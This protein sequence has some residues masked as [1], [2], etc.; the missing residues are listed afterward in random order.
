M[1]QFQ[2]YIPANHIVRIS[3]RRPE[4]VA[5][6]QH[7]DVYVSGTTLGTV[8]NDIGS[9]VIP[10]APMPRSLELHLWWS[11][12][13]GEGVQKVVERRTAA[14]HWELDCYDGWGD[15]KI[16]HCIQLRIEP[17]ALG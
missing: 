2:A 10:A 7:I 12:N 11:G 17:D 1:G 5:F 3:A 13:H 8:S 15:D 16:D 14:Q 6:D 4:Y 9:Y